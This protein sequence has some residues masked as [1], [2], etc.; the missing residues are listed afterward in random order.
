M[1]MNLKSL[2]HRELG[3]GMMEEQLASTAGG[4]C[5]RSSLF[6][7]GCDLQKLS[8]LEH[9]CE[10]LSHDCGFPS[11]RRVYEDLPLTKQNEVRGK[12]VRLRKNL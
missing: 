12:V 1:T 10:I 5:E 2:L 4:Q 11:D 3:E 8:Y 9:I 6:L 7:N